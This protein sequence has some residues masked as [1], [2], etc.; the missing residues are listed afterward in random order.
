MVFS[1]DFR[2]R[3]RR[4]F[5]L[6]VPAVSPPRPWRLFGLA[7][8]VVIAALFAIY[9]IVMQRAQQDALAAAAEMTRNL[10]ASLAEQMG[11]SI[12]TVEILLPDAEAA[13]R[14]G[15]LVGLMQELPQLRAVVGTDAAGR[16]R[17]STEPGLIGF[18]LDDREWFRALRLRPLRLRLGAPEAGR[19][20]A[21]GAR[22][23]QE[24]GLWTIPL[25][26]AQRNAAGEFEGAAV[27]LLNPDHF[28]GLAQRV[29]ESF[30][31]T[32]RV[33]AANGALLARSDG[34]LEGIGQLHPGSWPFRDFLPRRAQGSHDGPDLDGQPVLAAFDSSP[35]GLM[36]VE[37]ARARDAALAPTERLGQ[38]L[39]LSML[40]T[41]LLVMGALWLLLRQSRL[42]QEQGKALVRSEAA[43]L[44]GARAKEE[45]LASMSH[46]IRTPMNGVIGM[47]SL[48]LDSPLDPLQRRHAETIQHSAEHLMLLLNDILDL[49]KLEAGELAQERLPFD[50]EA[51]LATIMDLF[52]P[53]AAEKGVEL[54]VNLSPD[55]PPRVLGDPGRFRQLVFNLVGNAMKFT[56]AGAIELALSARP[57]GVNMRLLCAVTDTG[58]GLEKEQ[59]PYLFE[60]FTQA[61][62]SIRRR[63]GGSGLGLAICRRLAQQMGGDITARQRD[64]ALPRGGGSVFEFSVLT[65][66]LMGRRPEPPAALAGMAALVIEG[67]PR[68]TEL[69]ALGLRELGMSPVLASPEAAL[70]VLERTAPRL[71]FIP[72]GPAESAPLARALRARAPGLGT[73]L[74][75]SVTDVVPGE[76]CLVKPILPARLREAVQAALAPERPPAAPAGPDQAEPPRATPRILLVEDNA[77]NQL[78]IRSMLATVGCEVEVANNGL[79]AVDAAARE[80]FAVILMDVQ[81]PQMDGLE[82]TRQIRASGGPNARA[83]IIGLTAAAGPEY[84]RQCLEAGMD[85]YLTKPIRRQELLARLPL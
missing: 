8:S 6:G 62:A 5:G 49:S 71:A 13:I 20:L 51:E 56:E 42:L 28:S 22:G 64:P 72:Q 18:Q 38:L 81:M 43:A 7:A 27:A 57:E 50:P 17:T 1:R 75:T 44:A 29:A 63:Y 35:Q 39:A 10:A 77:T 69:L 33:S 82:A 74:V 46:E 84:E 14:T 45:F 67:Q 73:V 23:V 26:L 9:T 48:L 70:A 24:V 60:R 15:T 65:G 37:V 54:L 12:Q 4:A 55:L 34:R 31:V 61:D 25:A 66:R 76:L 19:Y 41:G 36:I 47:A 53:R 40:G 79:E 30:G 59:I 2:I 21:V 78:V 85:E 58:I 11:R 52:A 32:V 83:R 16:V 80:A 68:L 3:L